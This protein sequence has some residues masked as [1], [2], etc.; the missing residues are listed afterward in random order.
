MTSQRRESPLPDG[1]PTIP[2]KPSGL[3]SFLKSRSSGRK[4]KEK[5]LR[6]ASTPTLLNPSVKAALHARHGDIES[7]HSEEHL[8]QTNDDSMKR[9]LEESGS[10]SSQEKFVPRPLPKPRKAFK[11]RNSPATELET[12][13]DETATK[14]LPTVSISN[15]T[16]DVQRRSSPT[17][18]SPQMSRIS[19]LA[20]IDGSFH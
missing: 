2:E 13:R 4:S 11:R 17:K 5:R 3:R 10:N 14:E 1:K 7:S 12:Q 19:Y 15:A 20:A 8:P 18:N 6:S 9:R 16:A